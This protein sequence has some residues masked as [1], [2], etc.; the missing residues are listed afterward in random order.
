MR[1][2]TKTRVRGVVMYAGQFLM[3]RVIEQEKSE[4][5]S[6]QTFLAVVTNSSNEFPIQMN[7]KP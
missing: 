1:R 3:S 6:G 7:S 2:E 4:S 5:T